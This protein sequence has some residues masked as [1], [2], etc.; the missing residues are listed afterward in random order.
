[1][2]KKLLFRN[3]NERKMNYK[4]GGLT[5]K[6]VPTLTQLPYFPIKFREFQSANEEFKRGL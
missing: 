5:Q 6:E 3:F 1:M 4:T 2:R